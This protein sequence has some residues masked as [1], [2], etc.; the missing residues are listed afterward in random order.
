MRNVTQ[1]HWLAVA[2]GYVE[3]EDLPKSFRAQTRAV[4]ESASVH[5]MPP[6]D[7]LS[8]VRK[9]FS[10]LGRTL[11][12]EVPTDDALFVIDVVIDRSRKVWSNTRK[13]TFHAAGPEC[14]LSLI[15][16]SFIAVA[17]CAFECILC[18]VLRQTNRAQGFDGALTCVLTPVLHSRWCR[19]R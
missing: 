9:A 15:I 2:L 14:I 19:L 4:W 10:N 11:D 8:D 16:L 1:A 6:D 13:G 7:F 17:V 5:H 18:S 3:R 12:W